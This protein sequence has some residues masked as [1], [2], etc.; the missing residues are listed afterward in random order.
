MTPVGMGKST[1]G[2]ELATVD[3]LDEN[4]IAAWMTQV[5]AVPVVGQKR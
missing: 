1:R 2:V 3:D 5:A 4:Q